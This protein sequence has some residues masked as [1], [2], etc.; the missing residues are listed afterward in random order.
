MPLVL[1]GAIGKTVGFILLF[2]IIIGIVIGA[3]LFGRKK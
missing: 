2:C 3:M 1:A